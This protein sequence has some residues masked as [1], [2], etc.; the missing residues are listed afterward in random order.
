V[1]YNV[2]N[3]VRQSV[4]NGIIFSLI[5]WVTILLFY[6]LK[7]GHSTHS[8]YMKKSQF[9]FYLTPCLVEEKRI[10]IHLIINFK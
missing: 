9:Y 4:P 8:M 6:I 7:L 5:G 1:Q 2:Y 10:I 3:Y